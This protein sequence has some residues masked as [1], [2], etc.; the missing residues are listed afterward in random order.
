MSEPTK[1]KAEIGK[2]LR[3]AREQAGLS[4]GQVAGILGVHRPTISQIEAGQ[5]G[6]KAEEV[7]QFAELYDVKEDWLLRGDEAFANETDPRI[8]LAARELSK[9]KQE[10]LDTILRLMATP[11]VIE[12]SNLGHAW[13]RAF[14]EVLRHGSQKCPPLVVSIAGFPGELP[15]EDAMLRKSL[16]DHLAAKKNA[17]RIETTAMLIFPY[18]FWKTRTGTSC[19]E[20]CDLCLT[21][22]LPRHRKLDKRNR[23][24]TYFERMMAY[25]GVRNGKLLPVNPLEEVVRR[26]SGSKRFRATGL[27]ISCFD[28][29][30]DH[31]AQPRLG[32]PCL[33]Q[34]GITNEGTDGICVTGLY[35][36]QH[37]F[38]RAYGNYLGLAHLGR[39]VCDQTGLK[40]RRST[41]ITTHPLLGDATKRGVAEL[42]Q[43]ATA[44]LAT[45]GDSP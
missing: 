42:R 21:K 11:I 41:C 13:A 38:S 36:S 9:L 33:Q 2:R 34:V 32:F 8:E 12:E 22:L 37:I 18:K 6:V 3:C 27:Q 20:F 4:Q 44:S 43:V 26:L 17:V 15:E 23:H 24:G 28:P 7:S 5:R 45:Q 31:T 29:A 14:S 25:P 40:L 1:V 39:F 35:P 30:R 10:D 19:K 16:D